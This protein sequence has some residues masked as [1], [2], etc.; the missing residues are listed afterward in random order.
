VILVR[1]SVPARRPGASVELLDAHLQFTDAVNDAGVL[2]R[3][4]FLGAR[5]TQEEAELASGRNEEVLRAAEAARTAEV[6]L[7]A[8]EASRLGDRERAQ[9]LLDARATEL[10]AQG[11]LEQQADVASLSGVLGSA[12]PDAPPSAAAEADALD[13]RREVLRR[14]DQAQTTLGH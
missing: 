14:Y 8:V 7:A 4:L 9:A 11:F 12:A 10:R 13:L 6:V 3:D 2:E 1:A 5:A